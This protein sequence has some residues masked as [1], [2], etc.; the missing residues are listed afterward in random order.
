MTSTTHINQ[1]LV[2][3][4]QDRIANARLIAAAPELLAA[5]IFALRALEDNLQPGPI[6]R[7]AKEGL[8][9]AIAKAT[10]QWA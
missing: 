5:C 3:A 1:T 9:A 4:D 7:D 8:R 10:T 6:D 2:Q